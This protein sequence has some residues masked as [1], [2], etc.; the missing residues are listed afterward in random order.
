MERQSDEAAAAAAAATRTRREEI[1]IKSSCQEVCLMCR[2]RCHRQVGILEFQRIARIAITTESQHLQGGQKS[3]LFVFLASGGD[4][5]T[6]PDPSEWMQNARKDTERRAMQFRRA[7]EATSGAKQK[8][9][10]RR[11]SRAG[12]DLDKIRTAI[13]S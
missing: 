10:P 8:R 9:E 12:R 3:V 2:L 13:Y 1:N 7:R 11:Y 5:D 4:R 6:K